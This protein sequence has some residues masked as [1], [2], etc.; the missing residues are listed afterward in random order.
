MDECASDA[1]QEVLPSDGVERA[2][3]LYLGMAHRG[4]FFEDVNRGIILVRDFSATSGRLLQSLH[5]TSTD[6][7]SYNNV[8]GRTRTAEE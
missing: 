3:S 2:R 7:Q 4:R 1:S 5:G 8:N 6:Y